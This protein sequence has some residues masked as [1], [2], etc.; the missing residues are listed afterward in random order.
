VQQDHASQH[1]DAGELRRLEGGDQAPRRQGPPDPFSR[2]DAVVGMLRGSGSRQRLQYIPG[3]PGDA[4]ARLHLLEEPHV[5]DRDHR[6]VS[7]GG[8]QLDLPGERAHH[9]THQDDHADRHAF[10]QQR[11]AKQRAV[12]ADF[13]RA[14]RTC[15]PDRQE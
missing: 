14:L 9:A 15:I 5:L 2:M 6:L 8:D 7:E 12:A 13:A 4:P 3:K 11:N 1:N 10:A